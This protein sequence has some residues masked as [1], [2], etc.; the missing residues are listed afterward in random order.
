MSLAVISLNTET[1]DCVLTVDGALVSP[2]YI[3]FSKMLNMDGNLDVS[4]RY[5]VALKDDKT[6]MVQKMEFMLPSPDMDMHEYSMDKNG[7]ASKII[8]KAKILIEDVTNFI[9][10][11]K[12]YLKVI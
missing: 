10:K 6:G 9:N 1:R 2:D 4:F 11:R 8:D 5:E 7:L 3:Y 12:S